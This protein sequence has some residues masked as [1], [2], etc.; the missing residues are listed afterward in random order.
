MN[1]KY[2]NFMKNS[3]EK[4]VAIPS[5]KAA[6]LPGKPF[7][8]EIDRAL[9]ET[10]ALCASMGFTTRSLDGYCGVAEIGEGEDFGIL[11]HLDVVP[12]G[13][14]WLSDPWTLTE[15]DGK[16]F[17]RGTCD[18]K[19]PALAALYAVKAILDEG[20]A[21]KKKIKF[22]F[23][24][25]E[26]SG[27]ACMK[28]YEK[29]EKMPAMGISPDA[30]FPV[31]NC[32]KGILHLKLTFD[33]PEGVE[34]ISGGQRPNMVADS[35]T[36]RLTAGTELET[37]GVAAHG[38]TPEKGENAIV[39]MLGAIAREHDGWTRFYEMFNSHDGEGVGVK[40][41]D[42]ES[43][44]LTMNLGVV[45]STSDK[46]SFTIDIRFPITYKK[47]DIITRVQEKTEALSIE[48][49]EYQ[50]PLYV[51]EDNELV[52]ALMDAYVHVTG[53]KKA[54]PITIGGGTYARALPLGVAF[55]TTFPGE[56]SVAHMPNEYLS[57]DSAKKSL[58]I[59]YKALKKLCF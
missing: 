9:N 38:S 16:L 37:K 43:G 2:Y 29:V 41:S 5:V 51:A 48:Q 18:D 47:D 21:P 1:E 15:R 35:C 53:D 40:L 39:K 49:L 27:W 12:V 11:V 50:A 24:C 31:I 59:Y 10:L 7:G 4:L 36:A 3:L 32:E 33:K 23:G 19:G 25:D 56:P 42:K 8:G 54:R 52:T 58:E 17:G 14:G 6:P 55:G 20:L 26:E 46:V 57:V 45:A 22:I 44:N 30:D 13:G 34:V 28:H